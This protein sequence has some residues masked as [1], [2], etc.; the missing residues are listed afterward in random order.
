M[1]R[2]VKRRHPP[3][4]GLVYPDLSEAQIIGHQLV[5]YCPRAL[6]PS[7]HD[8]NA[9]GGSADVHLGS[10][11]L[12]ELQPTA[13]HCAER[14]R[15]GDWRHP[16]RDYR[17]IIRAKLFDSGNIVLQM[18][19]VPVR[20]QF[21]DLVGQ[22]SAVSS[23]TIGR[24]AGLRRPGQS[25]NNKVDA[26]PSKEGFHAPE[27]KTEATHRQRVHLRHS[28]RGVG[29]PPRHTGMGR[30]SFGQNFCGMAANCFGIAP[31]SE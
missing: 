17:Q 15:L 11:V 26:K 4:A 3:L 28:R 16:R 2:R 31:A 23:Y 18:R 19:G 27:T 13:L 29:T 9:G 12:D 24:V 1:R 25:R 14:T 7:R 30:Q 22:S 10:F 6:Q 8:H 5:P 20:F 21:C